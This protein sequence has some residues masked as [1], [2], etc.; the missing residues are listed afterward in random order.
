MGWKFKDG[1]PIWTQIIDT[2]RQ[3]IVRG[4]WPP[5][6]KVPAV[7][8]LALEAGVN[9]NTMQRALSEMERD[10]LL[11]SERTSGRFVTENE[12]ILKELRETLCQEAVQELL[13]QLRQLGLTPEEI[14][15]EFRRAEESLEP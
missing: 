12:E 6:S 15:G 3:K 5:G 8:E 13:A 2:I 14:R 7:R 9:P 1:I 4:D 10:G 11:Y